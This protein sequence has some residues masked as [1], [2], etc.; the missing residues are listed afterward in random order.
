MAGFGRDWLLLTSDYQWGRNTASGI[1]SLVERNGG[2]IVE[3]LLVPEN[4]RDF[5]AQLQKI[6]TL[7]A[8]VVATAVGGEDLKILRDQV[9][10]AGLDRGFGWINNQ[11]DWPDV[12]GLGREAMFGIFGTTWYWRLGLPGVKEFVVR[13]QRAS[14]GYRIKVPVT[15]FTTAMLQHVNCS[16]PLNALAQPTI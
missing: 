13:Y 2:R 16:E 15:C 1:R 14:A 8:G 3:E 4:T 7:N 11:Q 12:Y 10:K 5:S 6:R 9:R